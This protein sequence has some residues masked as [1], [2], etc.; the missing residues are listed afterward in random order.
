M[1]LSLNLENK[2]RCVYQL[3]ANHYLELITRT[4][5]MDISESRVYLDYDLYDKS[6]VNLEHP[7]S[8]NVVEIIC[9]GGKKIC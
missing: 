1:T 9:E 8:R 5:E 4:W 6:D 2:E 3:D 7:I